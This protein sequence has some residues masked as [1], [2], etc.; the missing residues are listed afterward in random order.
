MYEQTVPELG[1]EPCGL[2][3][4]D[5]TG[6]RD[7]QQLG[8]SHRRERECHGG[9]SVVDGTLQGLPLHAVD[10]LLGGEHEVAERPAPVAP[11]RL[12]LGEEV[13]DIALAEIAHQRRKM[14]V[15]VL[16]PPAKGRAGL[17]GDVDDPNAREAA[18]ARSTTITCTAGRASE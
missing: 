13:L 16:A 11:H 15:D 2:R 1:L 6:V 4:H 7:R 3:R 12:A 14:R 17:D 10:P 18:A 5:V 9:R 8:G